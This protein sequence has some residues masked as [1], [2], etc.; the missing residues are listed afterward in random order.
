MLLAI[1]HWHGRNNSPACCAAFQRDHTSPR[2]CD[3]PHAERRACP[4]G[5]KILLR[6][7]GIPSPLPSALGTLCTSFTLSCWHFL[8]LALHGQQPHPVL[9]F[10]ST[11]WGNS[12]CP[13]GQYFGVKANG[14][15]LHPTLYWKPSVPSGPA[16][17]QAGESWG[18]ACASTAQ[19]R[20]VQTAPLVCSRHPPPWRQAWP[21]A[22]CQ[23]APVLGV[24]VQG[25]R[26]TSH[27]GILQPN[28]S[29]RS[30]NAS[31]PHSRLPA[32]A[33]E[34]PH[35]RAA[36]RTSRISSSPPAPRLSSPVPP[37]VSA[38]HVPQ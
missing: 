12:H 4:A 9:P 10:C 11:S 21:A 5:R 32:A 34:V 31:A 15:A 14:R 18:S 17:T 28:S 33:G 3:K 2:V 6:P 35:P 29:R 24:P 19:C 25:S 27:R 30:E 1:H 13:Q 23:P 16:G 20:A 26:A 38:V 22:L 36:G 37:Q 8:P 7:P